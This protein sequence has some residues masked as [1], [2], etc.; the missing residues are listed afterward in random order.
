[1]NTKRQIEEYLQQM[2][3]RVDNHNIQRPVFTIGKEL[4]KMR[5][6]NNENY[7]RAAKLA[8]RAAFILFD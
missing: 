1:M 7:G 5:K 3:Y 8:N 2:T 4:E 6:E